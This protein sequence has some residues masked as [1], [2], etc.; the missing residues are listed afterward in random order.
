MSKSLWT[1]IIA[2]FVVV[3]SLYLGKKTLALEA[4][5]SLKQSKNSD[6]SRYVG[7]RF[8]SENRILRANALKPPDAFDELSLE[9]APMAQ[10]TSGSQLSDVQPTD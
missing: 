10:V 5:S 3:N 9:A 4:I 2:S 6:T 1:F 7:K 8:I